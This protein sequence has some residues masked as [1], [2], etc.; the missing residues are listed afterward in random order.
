M[1]AV[2]L[3]FRQARNSL[4][5]HRVDQWQGEYPNADAARIDM[6][7]I[8]DSHVG[9]LNL[10][11]SSLACALSIQTDRQLD[12]T[13]LEIVQNR[14]TE[15]FRATRRVVDV[16]RIVVVITRQL[17]D[18]AR[19]GRPGNQRQSRVRRLSKFV[20]GGRFESAGAFRVPRRTGAARRGRRR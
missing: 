13:V 9:E 1:E 4:K 20:E 14:T 7:R 12:R 19:A 8:V 2:D 11:R 18:A 6:D 5:K 16:V 10:F 17:D 15:I 3:I